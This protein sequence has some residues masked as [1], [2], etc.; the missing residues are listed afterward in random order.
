M[1]KPSFQ[2]LRQLLPSI[3]VND[4]VALIDNYSYRP[5]Y[6]TIRSQIITFADETTNLEENI[7]YLFDKYIEECVIKNQKWTKVDCEFKTEEHL[8]KCYFVLSIEHNG[9]YLIDCD[10]YALK[11]PFTGR[12]YS[13]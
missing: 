8:I 1:S 10:T 12:V 3:I 13:S 7:E 9:I 5:V 2:H 6:E 4:I 11:C